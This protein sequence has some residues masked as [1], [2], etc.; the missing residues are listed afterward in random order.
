MYSIIEDLECII[1]EGYS[2]K[3]N[4][5]DET[6][7]GVSIIEDSI[8]CNDNLLN[9][10]SGIMQSEV[11]FYLQSKRGNTY[12]KSISSMLDIKEG[13]CNLLYKEVGNKYILDVKCGQILNLGAVGDL[14]AVSLNVIITYKIIK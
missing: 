10:K 4:Y 3:L 1:P 5:V 13:V 8:S 9:N 7:E 11:Q 14:D 2:I 6:E 12:N